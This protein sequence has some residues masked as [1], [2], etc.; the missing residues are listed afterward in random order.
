MTQENKTI[1]IREV[2]KKG[3]R[4]FYRVYDTQTG[5]YFATG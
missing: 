5:C 4:T 3:A 1:S 2:A